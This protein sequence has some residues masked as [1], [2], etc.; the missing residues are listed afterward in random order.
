MRRDPWVLWPQ[1]SFYIFSSSI[2][3]N[4]IRILFKKYVHVYMHKLGATN[5]DVHLTAGEHNE[6]SIQK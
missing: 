3:D 5:N 4:K 2:E 1:A 6:E